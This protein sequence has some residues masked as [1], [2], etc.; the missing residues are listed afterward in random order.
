MITRLNRIRRENRALQQLRNLQF[1]RAEND[2]VLCYT[3]MTAARDNLILVI[4]SLDPF[5]FQDAFID[6]PID[7]F[8]GWRTRPT[9]CTTC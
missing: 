9:R 3:K 1:Q 4:V 8:A 6:V 2:F 7:Q 5:H